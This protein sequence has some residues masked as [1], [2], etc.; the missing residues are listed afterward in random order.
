MV[1]TDLGTFTQD[2]AGLWHYKHEKT[3]TV[4]EA[5]EDAIRH[6]PEVAWFWFNDTPAPIFPADNIE[7]LVGRW[8]H[9][10]RAHQNGG[11]NFLSCL[12]RLSQA[13]S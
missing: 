4:H 12:L 6:K 11:E 3:G 13:S 2:S 10:R 5:A 9:W 8:M 7:A 1:K